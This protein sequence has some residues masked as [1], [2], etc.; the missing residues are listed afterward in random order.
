MALVLTA[1]SA[2]E[3]LE[4]RGIKIGWVVRHTREQAMI[5][6]YFKFLQSG[7]LAKNC[8]NEEIEMRQI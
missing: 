3:L 8:K 4:V 1:K 6:K 5:T 7:H 2:K